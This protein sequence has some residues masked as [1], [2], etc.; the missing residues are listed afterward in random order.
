[1]VSKESESRKQAERHKREIETAKRK[2]G[3]M[4]PWIRDNSTCPHPK[5]YDRHCYDDGDL[6]GD[7]HRIGQDGPVPCLKWR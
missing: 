6:G 2:T 5:G 1:M 4:F 3:T 7:Q